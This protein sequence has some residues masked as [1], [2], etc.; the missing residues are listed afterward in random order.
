M[1][2]KKRLLALLSDN[3]EPLEN[4]IDVANKKIWGIQELKRYLRAQDVSSFLF[5]STKVKIDDLVDY[6]IKYSHLQLIKFKTPR[7]EKLFVWR[8]CNRFDLLPTLRPKG[9]YTHQTALY[10]HGIGQLSNSIYFNHEQ[11]VRPSTGML[12]QSRIDN[13]FNKGQRLTSSRSIYDGIEYW[14]LNGKQ[15]N[16]YGVIDMKIEGT[17]AQVTDLERTLVDIT[18]RPAYAGGVNNVLRSYRIARPKISI[19]KLVETLRVLNYVYPYY[20]SV[21]FYLDSAG[22]TDRDIQP[23]LNFKS[24]Q[25]DFYLDYKMLN[26]NY[27]EKWRLYYPKSLLI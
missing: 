2:M 11:P 19:Q 6:L 18:V 3:K 1:D 16:Q 4:S 21:G 27:S 25:Y 26:P 17:S 13:A 15:T 7:T 8:S 20:Q 23:F 12:E 5:D 24:F 14:L 10:F 9:Y 22:Y